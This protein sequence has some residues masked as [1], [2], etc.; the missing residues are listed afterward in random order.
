MTQRFN[1]NEFGALDHES[2]RSVNE[3]IVLNLIRERQPISRV[4][5]ARLTHLKQSTITSIVNSLLG[6]QLVYEADRGDSSGGRKPTLLRINGNR[7]VAV[8]IAVGVRNTEIALGNFNG[9]ILASC[10]IRTGKD[11]RQLLPRM[12]ERVDELLRQHGTPQS[13]LDG[14]G[15]SL[16]GLI[17]RSD[18]K[19]IYSANLGWRDVEV[20]ACLRRHYDCDLI[21][22][23]DMRSAGLAEI[24]FG[25]LASLQQYHIV[26][27]TVNEGIGTAIVIGG[28]LY[29]GASLGAGQFG[30]VSLFPDGPQC[31]CGNRGCWELYASDTATV[32]RYLRYSGKEQHAPRPTVAKLA[33]L[34]AAGDRAAIRALR[35]AGYY[36]G[37]GI[38]VLVNALNP[39]M[40][41]I[42]GE[43]SRAWNLAEPEIWDVVKAR[44][45]TRNYSSLRLEPSSLK[46]NPSLIGAISLVVCRRFAV[47]HR[48]KGR[49]IAPMARNHSGP[50]T[51]S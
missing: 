16:P 23:D 37:L 46:A 11:P 43:I 38:A 39:E 8:G 41:V 24:W 33:D 2:L 51:R 19:I 9:E 34:A 7:S 10:A 22:E 21:F 36:L 25:S 17:D 35:R 26:N 6:E 29:R 47:P 12:L 49:E 30:H 48:P 1:P 15:V 14:I 20:G 32:D 28:H 50:A 13:Q 31:D 45:L 27:V 4:D 40:I 18:G 5:L 3:S 44:T 42:Q